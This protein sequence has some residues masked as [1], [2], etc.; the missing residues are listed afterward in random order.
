MSTDND[1]LFHGATSVLLRLRFLDADRAHAGLGQGLPS[2]VVVDAGGAVGRDDD[3]DPGEV[4]AETV[5]EM[6]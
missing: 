4:D 3:G 2:H 6:L 5:V 1:G